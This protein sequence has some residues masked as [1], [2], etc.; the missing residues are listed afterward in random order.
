MNATK[1][2]FDNDNLRK[3]VNLAIDRYGYAEVVWFGEDRWTPT[4]YLDETTWGLKPEEVQKLPGWARGD[5][6]AAE[7]EEA[8]FYENKAPKEWLEA[9]KPLGTDKNKLF[10][11]EAPYLIAIFE[12]K[13][14]LKNQKSGP[15]KLIDWKF[16]THSTK[17]CI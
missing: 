14:S 16:T 3:A 10:L 11:E 4:R 5:A 8:D 7:I 12:K 13:Y 1:P 2:P 17:F 15:K 9:L 6:K